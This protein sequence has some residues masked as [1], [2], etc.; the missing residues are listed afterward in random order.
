MNR[1]VLLPLI[2]AGLALLFLAAIPIVF[3]AEDG[4]VEHTSV[5]SYAATDTENGSCCSSKGNHCVVTGTSEGTVII[6]DT[7]WITGGD[8]CP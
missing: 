4:V 8:P 5:T 6:P 2:S 7:Q 1:F 3:N